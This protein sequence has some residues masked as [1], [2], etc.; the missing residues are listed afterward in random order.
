MQDLCYAFYADRVSYCKLHGFA[1]ETEF[2]LL[3]STDTSVVHVLESDE[4]TK[5]VYPFDFRLEITQTLEENLLI[6]NWKVMNTGEKMYFSIGSHPAF[7][8]PVDERELKKGC[9]VLFPGKQHLNYIL[10][11]LKTG[12]A[13]PSHIYT[14]ELDN[15][16]LKLEDHLF[17]IDTFF[18]ED[19]QINEASVCGYDKKPYVTLHCDG[20]PYFDKINNC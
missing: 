19:G 9:Y 4:E 20:F 12:S 5:K 8:V 6:T 10:K 14:M 17:D 11:D 15:G 16:Y 7:R 3:H 1:R 2:R 13:D 18:F